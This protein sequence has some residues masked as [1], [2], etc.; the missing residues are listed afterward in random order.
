VA[1]N[2]SASDT[3][4]YLWAVD[5]HSPSLPNANLQLDIYLGA[6][7]T[8]VGYAGG[9]LCFNDGNSSNCGAYA[10]SYQVNADPNLNG[11]SL[12]AAPEPSSFLLMAGPVVWFAGRRRFRF[13]R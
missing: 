8:L 6:T 4:D 1:V 10:T 5:F 7:N 11:G 2:F 12:S 13:G 3:P 9:P